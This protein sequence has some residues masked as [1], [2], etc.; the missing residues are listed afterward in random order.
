MYS[1]YVSVKVSG[2]KVSS[3]LDGNENLCPGSHMILML[4]FT[5][6]E[7]T[8]DMVRVHA[9]GAKQCFISFGGDTVGIGMF[10]IEEPSAFH[11]VYKSFGL[12]SILYTGK[13]GMRTWCQTEWWLGQQGAESV[14]NPFDRSVLRAF[15]DD[16][17][18][19]KTLFMCQYIGQALNQKA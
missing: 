9:D 6:K 1:V 13:S 17:A 18:D 14:G 11:S 19:D 16:E 3:S 7:T 10:Q 2:Q 8:Q 5:W 12:V 15:N 4:L